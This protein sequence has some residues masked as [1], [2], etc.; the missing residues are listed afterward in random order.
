MA[1]GDDRV[2]WVGLGQQQRV[3]PPRLRAARAEFDRRVSY[4]VKSRT[5]LWVVTVC[6]YATEQLLA[7]MSGDGESDELPMLDAETIT[8]QPAVGCYVCCQLWEPRLR[9]RKCPGDPDRDL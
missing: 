7:A 3:D 2:G 8:G 1:T 5:H 4:A 6:H 9:H